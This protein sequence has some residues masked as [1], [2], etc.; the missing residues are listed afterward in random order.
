MTP[1]GVALLFNRYL[2]PQK[3]A[4]ITRQTKKAPLS[5]WLLHNS[6]KLLLISSLFPLDNPFRSLTTPV[7]VAVKQP[8][9]LDKSATRTGVEFS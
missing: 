3:K 7:C 2:L 6:T 8:K 9:T 4:S 5:A 1:V